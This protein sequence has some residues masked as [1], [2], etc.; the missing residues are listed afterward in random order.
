VIDRGEVAQPAFTP[1]GRWI[2]YLK[3]D[4][5]GFSLYLAPVN[6]GRPI[7]VG[8]AGSN[9]DARTRPVWAP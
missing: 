8:Q 3:A 4:N 9:V 1:D 7:K 2:S 5:S 6:G